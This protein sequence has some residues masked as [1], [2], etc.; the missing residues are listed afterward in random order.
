M[1][2]DT[3]VVGDEAEFPKAIHEETDARPGGPNHLC[4]SFLGDLRDHTFRFAGLPKFRHQEKNSRQTLFTGVE[5]LVDQI[6]LRTHAAGEEKLEEQI[7]EGMF[8]VHHSD[9][10]RPLNFERGTGANRGRCRQPKSHGSS[11]RFFSHKVAAG[12]KGNGSFFSRSGDD[13]QLGASLLQVKD[14]VRLAPLHKEALL[15]L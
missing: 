3:T 4:Q 13:S 2:S 14:G 11:E 8:L 9:H 12:E 1:Y 15:C 5:K 7:R 10:L 6:R